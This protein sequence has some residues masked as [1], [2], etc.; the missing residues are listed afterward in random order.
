[1]AQSVNGVTT[2]QLSAEEAAQ[3]ADDAVT[4]IQESLQ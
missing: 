4:D 2:G 3:E 1:V